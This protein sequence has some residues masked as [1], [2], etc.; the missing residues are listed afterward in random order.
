MGCGDSG[1][2]WA[3]GKVGGG[4]WNCTYLGRLLSGVVVAVLGAGAGCWV[5]PFHKAHNDT[6]CMSSL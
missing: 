3:G 6:D 2:E 4:R 1:S 5:V